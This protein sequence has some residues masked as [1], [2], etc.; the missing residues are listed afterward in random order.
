[1]EKCYRNLDHTADLGIEIW[2][3]SREALL[4]HASMAL[5]DQ[6]TDVTTVKPKR[7]VEWSVKG[8][9]PEELLMAQLQE[10]LFHLDTDGM[11]FSEFRISLR[12]LNA[13][14][15]LAYGETL[16]RERHHFKT[17]IKAVTYHRLFVGEEEG[18]WVARVIFDV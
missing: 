18:R 3:E 12:G 9:S 8:E 13:I 17:E 5:S 14:K 7:E 15:C 10:I 11:I 4:I 6:M 16:D 2:G 1:M